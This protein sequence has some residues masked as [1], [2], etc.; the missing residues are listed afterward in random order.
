MRKKVLTEI[1]KYCTTQEDASIIKAQ[2]EPSIKAYDYSKPENKKL[3]IATFVE[4]SHLLGLKDASTADENIVNAKFVIANFGDMTITEIRQAA[5]WSIVG[6]FE[7]DATCYGKLSPIYM[8][9]ILNAYLSYR[10]GRLGIMRYKLS[11]QKQ[12]QEYKA[13]FDKPLGER[14]ADTRAFLIKHLHNMKSNRA[15][16]VSGN[17][18]WKFMT[19][20][21]LVGEQFSPDAKSYAKEQLLNM[22][23]DLKYRQS[24]KTMAHTKIMEGEENFMLRCMQDFMIWTKLESI[25]DIKGLV[26]G[27]PDEIIIP[28]EQH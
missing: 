7:I 24:I 28:K 9:K 6:K 19:R 13:K 1:G 2:L 23:A 21:K 25:N 15:N 26:S 11:Q 8:A 5:H 27:Q 4:W 20:A 14:L 22:K 18:I 17:L 16:D 10:D 3:I 12:E